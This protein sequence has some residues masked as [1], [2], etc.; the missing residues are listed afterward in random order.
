MKT[1]LEYCHLWFLYS[2]T[3]I[4]A[5]YIV[6][7]S[8]SRILLNYKN[9]TS[10]IIRLNCNQSFIDS[11]AVPNVVETLVIERAGREI[12]SRENFLVEIHFSVSTGWFFI[13]NGID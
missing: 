3:E 11:L 12:N 9:I 1:F 13:I 8:Y 10:S 7:F 4:S 2:S 5:S 6:R